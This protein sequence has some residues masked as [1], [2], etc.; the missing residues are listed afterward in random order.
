MCAQQRAA[1]RRPGGAPLSAPRG[2][3]LPL[4]RSTQG[5]SHFGPQAAELP[6]ATL[7]SPKTRGRRPC[8]RSFRGSVVP[9]PT[10]ERGPESS[11]QRPWACQ[12]RVEPAVPAPGPSQAPG[13]GPQ[14]EGGAPGR[15]VARHPPPPSGGSRCL[16]CPPSPGQVNLTS[17][18]TQLGFLP[19]LWG[20][21]ASTAKK[22]NP[23]TERLA[24]CLDPA[25]VTPGT[26]KARDR[27]S[28]G[29]RVSRG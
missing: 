19:P 25:P 22:S 27:G 21:E 13:P 11:G 2:R 10:R 7:C 4:P 9:S 12:S 26:D 28:R 1:L 20:K 16:L 29:T 6:A 24:G 14:G 5:V 8:R 23:H 15:E 17:R 3:L 18:F